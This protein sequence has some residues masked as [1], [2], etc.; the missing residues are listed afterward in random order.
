MFSSAGDYDVPSH[1]Q[2]I[3]CA[4]VSKFIS[5]SNFLHVN[6]YASKAMSYDDAGLGLYPLLE[7]RCSIYF[8][9]I[10]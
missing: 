7:S 5:E 9:I 10:N 1:F 6:Q 4:G 8:F 2:W 3:H